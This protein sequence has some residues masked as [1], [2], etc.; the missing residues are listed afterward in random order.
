MDGVP[1]SWMRSL[2]EACAPSDV[3]LDEVLGRAVSCD[4]GMLAGLYGAAG[5]ME[6]AGDRSDGWGAGAI[7]EEASLMDLYRE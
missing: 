7:T 6:G 3:T 4:G 5:G 1:D 2:G